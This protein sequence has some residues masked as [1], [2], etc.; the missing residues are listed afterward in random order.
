M[1]SAPGGAIDHVCAA[2]DQELNGHVPGQGYV[3]AESRSWV[4]S[5]DY[6]LVSTYVATDRTG[7]DA[8]QVDP[9]LEVATVTLDSRLG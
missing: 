6:D 2:V 3:W 5:S 9:R 4:V 8:L 7:A 1:Y